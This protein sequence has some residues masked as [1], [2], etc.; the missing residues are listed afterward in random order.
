MIQY[1]YDRKA[2]RKGKF[3]ILHACI[4][5]IIIGLSILFG[6]KSATDVMQKEKW[7][8]KKQNQEQA[9]LVNEMDLAQNTNVQE[10]APLTKEQIDRIN[11]IYEGEDKVA[12]LTFDDGPS[13]SVTPFILDVL[14]QH[15]IKA[16]FFVLGSRVEQYSDLIKR[17]W[18][19]GHYIA[20]H[21]YS[22]RYKDIYGS[23]EA[24][25]QEYEATEKAIQY[26][27]ENDQY[28]SRLF[29][30]PGGSIGGHYHD[31]KQQAASL[32]EEKG[33]AHINWNALTNDSVG[34]PTKESIMKNLKQTVGE[35]K[36]VVILMHDAADKILTYEMLPEIIRYLKDWGYQFKNL[37]SVLEGE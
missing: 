7:E 14:K 27:L 16:T 23:K 13:P 10:M 19:E 5:T 33:I 35:K 20:N 17:E 36:V 28:H 37:G 26:A 12:Y 11:K 34:T 15:E 3:T 18:K 22:H 1:D 9:E 24:V 21:G 29:R 2:I 4:I 25:L 8:Q 31:I 32:L 6:M 30:F